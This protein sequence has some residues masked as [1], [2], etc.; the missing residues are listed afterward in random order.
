MP[1]LAACGDESDGACRPERGGLAGMSG[2]HG[3][4]GRMNGG[5]D[6]GFGMGGMGGPRHGGNMGGGALSP[7]APCSAASPAKGQ[8]PAR[9]REVSP[10]QATIGDARQ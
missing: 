9:T 8:T 6:G 7:S 4:G 1:L 10:D 3:F 2:H 5:M